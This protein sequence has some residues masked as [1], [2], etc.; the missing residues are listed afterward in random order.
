MAILPKCCKRYRMRACIC[1][2]TRHHS[3]PETAE[4]FTTIHHRTAICPTPNEFFKHF[5]YIVAETARTLLPGRIAAVHCMDV[6][7]QGANLAG[8][9]DFPGAIIKLHEKHGFEYTPRICIWK[10]PLAVRN[11]TMSKALA[12]R[13][14]VEDS[15]QVN[16]AAG[17][18]L[19]P[20]ERRV[21]ILFR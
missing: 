1:G 9:D 2:F 10:E 3:P 14:I 21:R 19:I 18:Y 5:E 16:V 8:F 4:L 7:L 13:Q 15:T 17:D 11:R 12:H 6:P 20:S